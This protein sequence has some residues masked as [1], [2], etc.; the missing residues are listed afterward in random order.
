MNQ[1]NIIIEVEEID[2]PLSSKN[3]KM[4]N[5]KPIIHK[6]TKKE[7]FQN[8]NKRSS[9]KKT[10]DKDL[11]ID[12][13]FINKG[14]KFVLISKNDR[15]SMFE[16]ILEYDRCYYLNKYNIEL[17]PQKKKSLSYISSITNTIKN[18]WNDIQLNIWK[19]DIIQSIKN[20]ENKNKIRQRI[21][22]LMNQKGFPDKQRKIIWKYFI[23][24]KL[25]ISKKLFSIYL[26]KIKT[27]KNSLIEKDIKRSF[28]QFTKDDNFKKVLKEA[29]ILLHIF[30]VK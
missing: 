23:G 12:K 22:M 7:N 18:K 25:K 1:E 28:H 9:H 3:G 20:N 17:N 11:T 21:F 15:E 10:I 8:N 27:D 29:N 2:D 24:N 30:S 16:D 26:K 13:N 5:K 4:I 14:E 19:S 6:I